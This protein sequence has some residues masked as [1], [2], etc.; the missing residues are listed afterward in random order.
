[1]R[2]TLTSGDDAIDVPFVAGAHRLWTFSSIESDLT[3]TRRPTIVH[4]N[5]LLLYQLSVPVNPWSQTDLDV[6]M[7]AAERVRPASCEVVHRV[8]TNVKTLD[9]FVDATNVDGPTLECD[10]E[11]LATLG[12][13]PVECGGRAHIRE[14]WDIA[15][16]LVPISR[17]SSVTV[18]C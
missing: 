10:R 18:S 7:Y 8:K 1:M 2:S 5:W 13:A 12:T 16:S 4:C 11:A 3:L 17:G 9:T 6:R 15:E 14:V